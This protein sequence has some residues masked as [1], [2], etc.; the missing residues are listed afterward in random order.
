[1]PAPPRN[2][3]RPRSSTTRSAPRRSNAGY[4][5]VTSAGRSTVSPGYSASTPGINQTSRDEYWGAPGMANI[6]T[7]AEYAGYRA[8]RGYTPYASPAAAPRVGGG[9]GGGGYG[10]GGGGGGGGSA[11]TQAMFNSMMQAIGASGPQ[12]RLNQVDLPD[13]V[14]TALAA[15]NAQ[16][17]TQAL[18]QISEAVTADQA[19][20][21][22]AAQQATQA[23]QGNYTNAYANTQVQGAPAAQQVG[24]A[25]QATAGGGGDQ[26]AVAAQS[27][28]AAGQDQAAFANL[29]NI[30]AAADQSAQSSR[31]NQVALDQGTATRGINAQALGL[32]G[33]VNTARAQ[34]E[35]QWRQAAAER[36]YQNSLM[37]QQWQR[38]ELT[39]N[40]DISNQQA[41]GNWQQ[42]NEMISSRLTPLLQ[43]LQGAGQGI[44][45]S[46]LQQ[47]LA[48]WSR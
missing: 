33:G 30:L 5:P 26:A 44:N 25:L 35:N 9:G 38:E 16:P 31:L 6:G 10:G 1:M 42:R 43:L 34:A 13:F 20:S 19:A 40:Q 27:N 28:Q 45:T 39:R 12:L 17:Y 47:L 18:G 15:F 23:L 46:A 2:P 14:G 8:G 7:T 4:N 3:W 22:A 41:Q 32:R 48:G 11:M 24:G 21:A 36:D 37:R 29:L